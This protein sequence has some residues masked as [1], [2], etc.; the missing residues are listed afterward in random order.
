MWQT[1][2]IPSEGMDV[3]LSGALMLTDTGRWQ[4]CVQYGL[5][6]NVVLMS[7]LGHVVRRYPDDPKLSTVWRL[8]PYP[9]EFRLVYSPNF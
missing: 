8:Y 4:G 3:K 1:R 5:P 9:A 6:K 7:N 2:K